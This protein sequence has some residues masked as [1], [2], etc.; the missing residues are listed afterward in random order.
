MKLRK[1]LSPVNKSKMKSAQT[2]NLL[3][4]SSKGFRCTINSCSKSLR[5]RAVDLVGKTICFLKTLLL[6]LSYDKFRKQT[7][8]F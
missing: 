1:S 6:Y 3:P 2:I 5:E 7:V 8:A 4:V